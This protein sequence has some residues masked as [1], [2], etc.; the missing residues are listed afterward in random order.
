MGCDGVWEK[1]S[2]SEVSNF[3]NERLEKN[4]PI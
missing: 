3:I 2:N 1:L 4:M